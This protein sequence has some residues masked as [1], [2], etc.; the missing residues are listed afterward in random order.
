MILNIFVRIID[1]LIFAGLFLLILFADI[2]EEDESGILNF[3]IGANSAASATIKMRPYNL[4]NCAMMI[5]RNLQQ[6][7]VVAKILVDPKYSK[8]SAAERAKDYH[9]FADY[10]KVSG[11]SNMAG[12]I[13]HISLTC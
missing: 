3:S 4:I 9:A 12:M 7:D 2:P 5:M 10:C 13:D 6:D 8:M 11:L 1:L